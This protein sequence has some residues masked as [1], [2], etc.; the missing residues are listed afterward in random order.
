MPN[1]DCL[2][3]KVAGGQIPA[4]I[5]HE[6]DQL[7][8]FRDIDPQAPIHILVIPREHVSS[9]DAAAD[10]HADLLGR[11]LLTARDLARSEGIADDGYRT[12]LNVGADGG[13]TVPHVHLHLLGGRALRW[14]PG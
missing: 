5:V 10:D 8:A 6:D 14:P 12:V 2:F 3:C 7:V 9:L 13:Q 11:M 4:T 1:S